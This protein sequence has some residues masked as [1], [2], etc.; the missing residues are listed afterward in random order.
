MTATLCTISRD[1]AESGRFFDARP[2]FVREHLACRARRVL[3]DGPRVTGTTHVYLERR[4]S[5]GLKD[6]RMRGV[7]LRSVRKWLTNSALVTWEEKVLEPGLLVPDRIQRANR[8]EYRFK[9]GSVVV[10]AGLD[11][12]QA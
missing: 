1:E 11:D 9:N 12:A 2:D 4:R 10:V 8:S 6:P 7:I 5:C 3:V